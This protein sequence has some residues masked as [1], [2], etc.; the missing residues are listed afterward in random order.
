MPLVGLGTWQ[1]ARGVVGQAVAD[2]LELGYVHIDCAAAYANECE[3]GHAL[4]AAVAKGTVT[5]EQ[6]FIT[7]KL[8]NDRRRPEDVRAALQQSL[9]D[10][11]LEYL[12]LYLIH[13]PVVWRRGTLMQTDGGASLAACWRALEAAVDAGLVRSIGV[14]NF[15]EGQMAELMAAARV[16]PAVNQVEI[17]PRLP[18]RALVSWCQ[19]RGVAVTAYSPLARGG[20]LFDDEVVGDIAAKHGVTPAQA[21]LRWGVERGIVVI[22][23]S[24]TASRIAANRDLFSFALDEEDMK[25]MSRLDDGTTTSTSPWSDSGPTAGRNKVLKPLISTLLWP[26]FK[27][28]SVDVQRMGRTGFIKWSW[29]R[30]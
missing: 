12:D 26:V 29:S 8:W 4:T 14:S 28:I 15:D 22:P 1:A 2:A 17:H 27:I 7:S 5:R 9:A 20:G 23:K 3:V 11:Q 13:W 10:L 21:V 24:V 6:L 18:Q 30:E 16:Q 19:K 25:G